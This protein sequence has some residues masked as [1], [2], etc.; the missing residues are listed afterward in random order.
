L[1][2]NFSKNKY[3]DEDQDLEESFEEESDDEV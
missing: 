2:T 1:F 3:E